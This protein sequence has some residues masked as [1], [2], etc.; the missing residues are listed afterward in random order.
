M[1]SLGYALFALVGIAGEDDLDAPDTL[2]GP[3][4]ARSPDQDLRDKPFKQSPK[5]TVHKPPLLNAGASGELR[6][7]LVTE[8]KALQKSDQLASWTRRRLPAKNTLVVDDARIVEAT[9]RSILDTALDG[10]VLTTA[11]DRSVG[12][13]EQQ[14]SRDS[15]IGPRVI[16]ISSV[17]PLNKPVRRRSKA[18]FTY[19][20]AQACV[21]C[22]RQPCDAHHLK[23]AQT[24][25]MG[26]KVSDE[27]TV[28]MSGRHRR[29]APTP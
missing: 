25:A 2:I 28:P 13:I 8:L 29:H 24:R 12:A 21:V 27:F 16:C 17:V 11:D 1:V 5:P 9:Y 6:D 26:R 18:H 22:Q 4:V 3:P 15:A 20:R 23:F 10:D 14:V 19:V 7:A